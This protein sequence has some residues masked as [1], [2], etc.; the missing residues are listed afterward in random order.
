MADHPT[1]GS[2]KLSRLIAVDALRGLIILVMALDHANYFIAQQHSTG[3][4][5][6]GQ[7]P[8]YPDTLAF[9][10]RFFT[11]PAAPGF[12]FLMGIGMALF[13]KSRTQRGWGKWQIT[14][15]FL[16]RGA[17]LIA[18]QFL[19]VNRAWEL[20][21]LGWGVDYYFGVLV[22]L[23]GG[24]MLGG[25]LLWL[26]PRVLLVLAVALLLGMELLT[27][28]MEQWG[29]HFSLVEGVLLIPSG[30]VGWWVNY[31]ILQWLELVLFGLVFGYWLADDPREAMRK[32]IIYGTVFLSA[33]AVIRY[34]DGFGN[35]RPRA[36]DTWID[37]LNV[38]K[39]PPSITFTLLTMSINLILLGGL[40]WVVRQFTSAR[41]LIQPLVII[42][43]ATLFFYVLHLF[44]YAGLGYLLAPEGT[45]IPVMYLFWLLG[46]MLLLP[47]CLWFGEMKR[48]RPLTSPLRLL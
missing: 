25:L 29:S 17:L 19:V 11:H 42:G 10:T 21:P 44:L 2:S 18:L 28:S 35:I 14:R 9:L 3:E 15:F 43:R 47:Y 46:V 8:T 27:P 45:N 39:Y 26:Q 4:Y 6:G 40:N 36:G 12:S 23:G 7:F 5:W 16:V 31:P 38:V 1:N 22:A 32:G 41:T 48:Q 34:L 20:S 30:E 24:M 37:F 13:A 33:F